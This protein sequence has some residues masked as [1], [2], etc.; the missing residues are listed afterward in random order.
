MRTQVRSPAL[1]SGLRIWHCCELWCRSQMRFGSCV[2]V[3][4]IQPL[5]WELPYAAGV[6]LKKQK[7]KNKQTKKTGHKLKLQFQ[8]MNNF[9]F[10]LLFFL[11]LHL[12]HMEVPGLGVELEL[13]LQAYTTATATPDPSHICDL[14][15]LAKSLTQ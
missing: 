14:Y 13:Q 3:A 6:A 11:W 2:A 8:I 12:Q 9:S 7:T 4:P 10:F 5:A 1:L 15:R